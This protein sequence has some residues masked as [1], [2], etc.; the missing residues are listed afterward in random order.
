MIIDLHIHG[1]I[2]YI[3]KQYVKTHLLGMYYALITEPGEKQ[4]KTAWSAVT[5]RVAIKAY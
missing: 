2:M 5:A 1:R 4:N 3:R